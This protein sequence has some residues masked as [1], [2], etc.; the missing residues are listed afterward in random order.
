MLGNRAIL[1]AIEKG[2]III[3]PFQESQLGPNSYD[4]RLGEWIVR[5]RIKPNLSGDI[6][7]DLFRPIH[8][9]EKSNQQKLWD[10]PIQVQDGIVVLAPGELILAHTEEIVECHGDIVGE[11]ASRST[12]MRNGIAVCV[13]AGLGDVG[14][15]SRWTME[16]Y[17][18]TWSNVVLK[19]GW[20][21]AQMKFHQVI[22]CDI[23][24]EQKGG[25]Y[26]LGDWSPEDM[27]PRGNML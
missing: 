8:I 23:E 13:D 19:V 7:G 16:I 22:G 24:Y 18:H 1:D 15:A 2:K 27:I 25:S 11:M 4:L 3:S 9:P 12:L 21:V 26:G 14:Y 5:Q 6:L 20:R 10:S 17:N